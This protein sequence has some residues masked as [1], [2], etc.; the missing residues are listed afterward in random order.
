MT[1]K[2]TAPEHAPPVDDAQLLLL[3]AQKPA[4]MTRLREVLL[5][6]W[7]RL[8]LVVRRHD[9]ATVNS[10]KTDELYRE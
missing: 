10:T 5:H 3:L 2:L 9:I 4:F 6:G 8:E 1:N 7:G